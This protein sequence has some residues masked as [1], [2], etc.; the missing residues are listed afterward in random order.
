[1]HAGDPLPLAVDNLSAPTDVA[2][3]IMTPAITPLLAAAQARGCRISL[4]TSMLDEQY[5]L[6]KTLLRIGAPAP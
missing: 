1:M 4:G 5:K 6:L 2:E 3:I